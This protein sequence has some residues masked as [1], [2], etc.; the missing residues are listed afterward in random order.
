MNFVKD[1]NVQKFVTKNNEI[2]PVGS[3]MS[4]C[5]GVSKISFASL[6]PV[7]V[8][9]FSITASN[10]LSVPTTSEYPC[11]STRSQRMTK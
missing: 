5:K 11:Y 8:K 6:P 10:G 4:G 7:G 3:G 9:M 2:S 1:L